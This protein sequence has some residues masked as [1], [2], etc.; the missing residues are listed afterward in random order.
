LESKVDLLNRPFD[1]GFFASEMIVQYPINFRTVYVPTH[2][3]EGEN[4]N[5]AIEIENI[6][7]MPLCDSVTVH[8]NLGN[9]IVASDPKIRLN[10]DDFSSTR[11]KVLVFDIP[12]IEALSVYPIFFN[13]QLHSTC[14]LFENY[15]IQIQLFLR[16]KKIEFCNRKIR[17]SPIYNPVVDFKKSASAKVLFF[18]SP[19]LRR[20]DFVCFSYLLDMLNLNFDMWDIE[21]YLHFI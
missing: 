14:L 16:H 4:K 21:R 19:H 20:Q 2:M 18:T 3:G 9:K 7:T 5:I 11:T 12:R 17:M 15:D 6:S 8:V 13:I 1:D 10:S